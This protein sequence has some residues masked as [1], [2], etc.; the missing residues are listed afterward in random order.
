MILGLGS[1]HRDQ[2]S[3][4]HSVPFQKPLQR[5]RE[6]VQAI[7]QILTKEIATFQGEFV[8][9]NNLK[10]G[11]RP[12]KERIP[13]FVACVGHGMAKVAGE[14]ADGAIMTLVSPKRA[15][16]LRKSIQTGARKTGRD[17]TQLKIACYLPTFLGDDKESAV[18]SAK[19]VVA[20]YAASPFYRR[21][22][23]EM[24]YEKETRNIEDAYAQSRASEAATHVTE[25]MARDI[26]LIGSE[27]DCR[28]RIDEY[29]SA[30]VDIP[31]L[32]PLYAIGGLQENVLP[33][34]EI[35]IQ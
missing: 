32:Q 7:N 23:R 13:I 12:F 16:E 35:A 2:I 24:G 9:V 31:I 20:S 34:L 5:M 3:T 18:E 30:G 21:L 33:S 1:G 22:F 11:V 10:L 6:Y 29:R 28:R 8:N 25:H 15:A 17:P 27:Q 26:T 4:L 14:V 19:K